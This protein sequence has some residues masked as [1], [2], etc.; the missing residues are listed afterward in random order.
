MATYASPPI[1]VTTGITAAG[2]ESQAGA[3]AIGSVSFFT[4]V[5]TS[6]SANNS[7]RLPSEP[8][9]GQIYKIR[10]DAKVF[11]AVFPPTGGQI[12]ALAANTP[13]YVGH[14]AIVGLVCTRLNSTPASQWYVCESVNNLPVLNVADRASVE[15]DLTAGNYEGCVVRLAAQTVGGCDVKIPPATD[16]PGAKYTFEMGDTA[17]EA[18]TITS[19]GC[20]F[21]G[22]LINGLTAGSTAVTCEGKAN[23]AFT[24]DATIGTTIELVSDG[25]GWVCKGFAGTDASFA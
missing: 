11:V 21:D 23:V 22:V 3:Y 2:G 5:A 18:I 19:V 12:N 7:L 17:D 25:V 10:N 9:L 1:N 20:T 4:Q 8:I 16:I 15:L 13:Y 6:T 14:K 24:A